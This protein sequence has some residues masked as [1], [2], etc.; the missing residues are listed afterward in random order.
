MGS[1]VC[2]QCGLNLGWAFSRVAADRAEPSIPTPNM[3]RPNPTNP[4][5]RIVVFG[6]QCLLRPV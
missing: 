4:P 2:P 5:A 3:A 1:C 6:V